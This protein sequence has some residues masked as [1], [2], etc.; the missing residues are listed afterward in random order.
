MSVR[1]EVETELA[2]ESER[3]REQLRQ[4]EAVM[5]NATVAVF[6]MDE[7]QQCT[8]M[9]P[10][11]E[12]LTGYTL[13]ELC[14]KPLH[15]QIHHTRPDG[16]AYPLG[17]CPIDQVF[18]QNMREQGEEVFVHKDGSFY[19][20]AFTASPIRD[21]GRT[22]GTV[23]EVRAIGE[24][25]Q[26]ERERELLL[27]ELRVERERLTDVFLQAPVSVVVLRGR[28][29]LD[30]VFELVNPSYLD[31][32]PPGRRPLGRKLSEVLPEI[33]ED[34]VSAL[35]DVLDT[36]T[37]FIAHNHPV[38][39]DRDNDG[40]AETYWFNFVYHPLREADGTIGGVIGVGTEVTDSVRA[41]QGA[42]ALQRA[43]EA[44]RA[45]AEAAR[46][47]I[48]FLAEASE[49]LSRSR[50]VSATMQ[51]IADLAVPALAS[52]CFLEVLEPDGT[53]KPVAVAHEDPAKVQFAYDII[54]RYPIDIR[55]DYGTG[56][57]LRTGEPELVPEVSDEVLAMVAQDAEHLRLLREVGLRSSL[58]VPLR[59]SDG[60]AMAVL[61]L[62]S[63][64]P[65]RRYGVQDLAMAQEVARRAE[66]ALA[67]ARLHAA[68]QTAL[69]RA[70]A[71]QRVT[72]ALSGTLSAHEAAAVVVDQGTSALGALIGVVV[73]PT[74]D[75]ESLEIEHVVGIGDR[76][77]KRWQRFPIDM[78]VPLARAVRDGEPV[79]VES[80]EAWD[81]RFGDSS[82]LREA[83][84]ARSWAALPL[85]VEGQVLGAIG[86]SFSQEGALGAEDRAF[87]M[88]LAQQCAQ[89][90]D[91]ARLFEAEREAREE[92]ER[93]N[94]AKGEFLAVMSHELRTPL[95]AIAGYAELM[96]M[97]LRGPVTEDQSKDLERIQTSQRHLLG[98]INEVLNYARLEMGTVTYDLQLTL[99]AEAIPA[100]LALV[101][102]QRSQKQLTLEVRL[103]ED[104]PGGKAVPVLAD[105][106]KL[107]QILINLLSNAV[108]FT[109][110]G[111]R[112]T[113]ELEPEPNAHG[114]VVLRVTDT[115]IGVPADK[116]DAIFE[117]F[118]QVGRASNRPMEGTGLG[119]AISRDLARG[120]GGELMVRSSSGDGS[121]FTLTLRSQ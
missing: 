12:R 33:D 66:A 50:N 99:V 28:V 119:L 18:P 105:P 80:V 121:T 110:P 107:Q 117:P 102:P 57:V 94:Q 81:Q 5:E 112:V 73:R 59:G 58:S 40:T 15:D 71:L 79:F 22:I 10:A 115:G 92:A 17:E 52:W 19:E 34:L 36:G 78:P 46:Q 48:A 109:P 83:T 97:G 87:A 6:V 89:A 24:E 63:T 69:Q 106:D 35:Q 100:A 42:E 45:E 32:L 74:E 4:R 26:R 101:E 68:E 111:G 91:R 3:L 60:K 65:G 25:K 37:P 98:L 51:A 49:R 13:E 82:P 8:Y 21:N 31:V 7:R 39:L 120:M 67:G 118:V 43:S 16:R 54:Q 77:V 84:G 41:R 86:F 114:M 44:A 88:A 103:P 47:R 72:A 61:S 55:A 11:A 104:V 75:G 27:R 85:M 30:L 62:V 56:H 95:N 1:S 93:A 23:I 70:T 113:V 38:S 76:A 14:G 116:L 64:E 53:V 108:K 9:N 2:G 20:V 96:A 29:A 90:F